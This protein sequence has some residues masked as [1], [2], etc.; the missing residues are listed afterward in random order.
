M[1]TTRTT[2]YLP[3]KQVLGTQV[4]ELRGFKY[5]DRENDRLRRTA[6]ARTIQWIRDHGRTPQMPRK[7][8][9]PTLW[10]KAREWKASRDG[11]DAAQEHYENALATFESALPHE[12]ETGELPDLFTAYDILAI[13]HAEP[14]KRKHRRKGQQE[15]LHAGS[16]S[17]I[18]ER[19]ALQLEA[20]EQQ[21]DGF[22]PFQEVTIRQTGKAGVIVDILH[23]SGTISVHLPDDPIGSP[24]LFTPDELQHR[25]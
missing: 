23:G 3:V 6:E 12:G 15:P 4:L 5:Y 7:A 13:D 16:I 20:D 25:P 10:D 8:K 9:D 11:L 21:L 19:P 22:K 1:I 18:S 17:F 24:T 14:A 2:R